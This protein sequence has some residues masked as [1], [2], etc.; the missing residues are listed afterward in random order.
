[1]RAMRLNG[2]DALG[3]VFP[4]SVE[5]PPTGKGAGKLDHY[6]PFALGVPSGIT[7]HPMC[8]TARLLSRRRAALGAT[9]G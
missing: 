3:I 5:G 9:L 2:R 1:M 4:L 6:T 7:R 8:R